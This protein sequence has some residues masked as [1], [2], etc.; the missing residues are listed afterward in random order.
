MARAYHYRL[1][2][3]AVVRLGEQDDFV[4]RRRCR[5]DSSDAGPQAAAD[6]QVVLSRRVERAD[7][8]RDRDHDRPGALA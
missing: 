7:H 5:G 2:Q 1:E 3:R 6:A 8:Q 4:R